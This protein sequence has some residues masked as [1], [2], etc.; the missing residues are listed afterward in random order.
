M[1]SLVQVFGLSGSKTPYSEEVL[2]C[3]L[4]LYFFRARSSLPVGVIILPVLLL[5]LYVSS[6]TEHRLKILTFCHQKF[7]HFLG[8]VPCF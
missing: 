5:V 4:G 6:I 2:V 1:S 7:D 8:M 3:P